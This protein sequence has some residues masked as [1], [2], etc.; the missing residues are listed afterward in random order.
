MSQVA[1]RS[2]ACCRRPIPIKA[3]R[4]L[5]GAVVTYGLAAVVLGGRQRLEVRALAVVA[6]RVVPHLFLIMS[7]CN[8]KTV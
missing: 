4:W 6:D 1:D 3:L 7:V 5:A 2:P 8:T